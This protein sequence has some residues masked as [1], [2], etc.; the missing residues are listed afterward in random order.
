M[1]GNFQDGV[2]DIN[3][4]YVGLRRE[5]HELVPFEADQILDLGASDGTL[6]AFLLAQKPGRSVVG[7]ELDDAMSSVA[8]GRLTHVLSV[9]IEGLD[10]TKVS[11]RGFFDC[12]VLAD[13]LEHLHDPWTTLRKA[14]SLLAEDGK[15]IISVPNIRHVSAFWS[16]YVGGSFP[17]RDRGIFDRTHLRWFTSRNVLDLCHEAGLR[18][19]RLSYPLR[20]TDDPGGLINRVVSRQRWI[21]SIP[22]VREL[23]GYQV[24]VVA[25]L[26]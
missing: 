5:I 9:D 1:N 26:R 6:G 25:S 13:V 3:T 16:I 2:E 22:F 10:W 19:D 24:V 17:R 20:V 21:T 8:S 12:I 14:S 11:E 18:V 15:V 23:L 4:A 7:V